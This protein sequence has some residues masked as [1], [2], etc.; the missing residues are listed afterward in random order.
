MNCKLKLFLGN[1]V[2]ASEGEWI[3]LPME[4]EKLKNELARITKKY[5]EVIISSFERVDERL[6][7]MYISQYEDIEK[8]NYILQQSIE[9]IALY[10][11]GDEDLDF[12]ESLFESKKYLF[13]EGVSDTTE[14]GE[15][16]ARKGLIKGITPNLI[17]T[18][19]ISFDRIGR[20]FECI[21]IRIYN[22]LGAIGQISDDDFLKWKHIICK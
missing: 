15:A 13:F 14:L 3:S 6:N 4:E 16:V 19:Y 9:F 20:D 1:C 17:D 10:M 18:G 7:D 11:C 12:A 8:I 22:R 21:G 5:G 2:Y